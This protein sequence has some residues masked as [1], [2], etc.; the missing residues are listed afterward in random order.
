M[1]TP[2]ISAIT[3][4]QTSKLTQLKKSFTSNVNEILKCVKNEQNCNPKIQKMYKTFL[5]IVAI[6][7]I[8]AITGGISMYVAKKMSADKL[9]KAVKENN[10]EKVQ[11]LL[12]LGENINASDF[13]GNTPLL[14]ATFAKNYPMVQFLVNHQANINLGNISGQTPLEAA[15]YSG[16]IDMVQFFINKSADL[17]R[18]YYSPL[19]VAIMTNRL[20]I[21]KLLLDAGANTDTKSYGG[22]P[23]EI[24]KLYDFHSSNAPEMIR[25]LHKKQQQ[26]M[27]HSIDYSINY[28]AILE[29]PSSASTS[30]I[31]KSFAKLSKQYHPDKNPSPQAAEKFKAV[32]EAYS[33]LSDKQ[34]RDQYDRYRR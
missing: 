15:V 28:Y 4:G 13:N 10:I 11:S 21:F 30:D 5:A 8:V 9:I 6:V 3:I 7:S 32:S 29:I 22:T 14:H 23:I 25:L 17:D 26:T 31:K 1:V 18:G 34:K 2:S 27:S 33:V 12:N 20:D 24:A 19:A 16:N